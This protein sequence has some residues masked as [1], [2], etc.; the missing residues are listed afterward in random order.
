MV[1][2]HSRTT[3]RS[4][5]KKAGVAAAAPWVI[6]ASSLGGEGRPAPSNRIAMGFVGVGA[7]GFGVMR[8][9]MHYPEVQNVAVCDVDRRHR[10]RAQRY[11]GG[12]TKGC[13]AYGDYRELCARPD[14]DA[15]YCGAGDRWH[16]V[17]SCTAMRN[18]KDVHC[19]KPE[20]LTIRESRVMVETARRTARVCS[21]GSQ[22]AWGENI[23]FHRMMWSGA[24]GELKEVFVGIGKG[25]PDE[26][27]LPAEPVP[28]WMDWEMWLGPAPW[29]PYNKLYH[30]RGGAWRSYRDFG[31][32]IATDMGPHHVGGA[33]FAAQM[34]DKPLPVEVIRHGEDNPPGSPHLTFKYANGVLLHLGGTWGEHQH[35]AFQRK[36]SN[37][38]FKGTVGE[39]PNRRGP[40]IEPPAILIPNYKGNPVGG[41]DN[42]LFGDFLHCVKTRQRPFRDI[43]IAHRTIVVCHLANISHWVGRGFKFDPVKE[44][45]IGDDQANRLVDRAHR[46]P[47]VL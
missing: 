1:S 14:I 4:F 41:W 28:E 34:H 35:P 22:R 47:W 46:A 18:G 19:E 45:I 32:G 21:G 42:G 23:W 37:L 9:F 25:T 40:R 12:P 29:R 3:R 36:P 16:A 27:I 8:G 10:E 24:I 6:P 20:S 11:A 33:L 43:D 2:M 26:R 44:Q 39:L 15:V 30:A 5:L 13:E 38:S 7:R 31:G 17:I